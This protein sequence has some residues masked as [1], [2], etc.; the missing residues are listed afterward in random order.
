[1]KNQRTIKFRFWNKGFSRFYGLQEYPF[2][3]KNY[4]VSQFTGLQDSKGKEIYE[5]DYISYGGN[6]IEVKYGEISIY[7]NKFIGF[8]ANLVNDIPT[9]INSDNSKT[10]KVIGNIFENPELIK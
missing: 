3:T 1:M 8:Y 2:D 6:P 4:I 7:E 10:C 9:L 5:G